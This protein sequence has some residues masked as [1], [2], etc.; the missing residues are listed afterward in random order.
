MQGRRSPGGEAARALALIG[1]V[2]V[3]VSLFLNWTEA[4]QFTVAQTGFEGFTRF[5]VVIVVLAALAG[6]MALIDAFISWRGLLPLTAALGAYILGATM[7]APIEGGFDGLAVG[8]YFAMIFSAVIV[9]GGVIAIATSQSESWAL[10]P[11]SAAPADSTPPA[12]WY[13]DPWGQS[14]RRYWSGTE[15]TDRIDR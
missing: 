7:L 12:G 9:L 8:W 13:P 6:A 3:I 4:G 15:W 14:D 2:G 1:S 5:D 10:E 11:A